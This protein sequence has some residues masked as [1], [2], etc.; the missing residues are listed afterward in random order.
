MSPMKAMVHGGPPGEPHREDQ[1]DTGTHKDHLGPAPEGPGGQH[2]HEDDGHDD[3][4]PGNHLSGRKIGAQ[5][6]RDGL[7]D[8]VERQGPAPVTYDTDT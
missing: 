4:P 7:G 1:P 2:E 5:Q 8:L 6:V 3:G